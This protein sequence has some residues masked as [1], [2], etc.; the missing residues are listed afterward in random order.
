MLERAEWHV[1]V[2][3]AIEF[4]RLGHESELTDA[5]ARDEYMS[6]VPR[7]VEDDYD[8]AAQFQF[9]HKSLADETLTFAANISAAE[10]D[11]AASVLLSD[12]WR[13]LWIAGTKTFAT[14][15][16]STA[17]RSS[18]AVEIS[19]K[20]ASTAGADFEKHDMTLLTAEEASVTNARP[21]RNSASDLCQNWN[22][23]ASS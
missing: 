13:V 15:A 17:A 14:V 1:S 18:L 21:H 10:L 3:E 2:R 5:T 6:H 8:D 9:W 7:R 20:K 19:P 16:F 11:A 12:A 4:V 22:C 23:A